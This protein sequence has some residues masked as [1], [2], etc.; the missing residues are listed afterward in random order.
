[1]SELANGK[2]QIFI[3]QLKNAVM[4]PFRFFSGDMDKWLREVKE[5]WNSKLQ[6]CQRT[7]C[8]QVRANRSGIR[9]VGLI[10]FNHGIAK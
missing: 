10:A 3:G 7:I 9:K 1:M 4:L 2:F 5:V 8:D 6:E